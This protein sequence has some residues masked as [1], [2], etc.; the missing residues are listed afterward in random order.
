MKYEFWKDWKRKTKT[1]ENAIKS[2][3]KAE[4]IL[5]ETIPREKIVAV[6]IK[7]SFVR[8]E[9]NEK[10]DV[11]IVPVVKDNKYLAKIKEL[12]KKRGKEYAPSELLPHSIWEFKKNKRYLEEKGPKG[13]PDIFTRSIKNHRL[14]Y[15]KP[16]DAKNFIIRDDKE[17]LKDYLKAFEKQFLLLYK[18]KKFGFQEI[19]KSV[20]WL[21]E[22]EELS[23]GK[24]PPHSWKKLAKSIKNKSHIVHETLQH[25]L[26]PTKDKKL[27][28][29]YITKLKKHLKNLK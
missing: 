27:R 5:F 6:Y 2:I 10:S 1:E 4:K 29:K 15:G 3:K 23:K 26:N 22:L 19:I 16:L 7:G 28:E 20:F 9:M 8:R 25:R 17:R 18:K 14:I 21:V 13:S 11:D 24:N 12:Q